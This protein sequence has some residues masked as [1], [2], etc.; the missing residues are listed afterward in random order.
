MED[1]IFFY[2]SRW[3]SL[4]GVIYLFIFELSINAC[5]VWSSFYNT[6]GLRV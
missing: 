2:L 4:S 3:N 1:L 5:Q 6:F